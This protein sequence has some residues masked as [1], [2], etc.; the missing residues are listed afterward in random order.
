[1]STP[2]LNDV[3]A[4]VTERIGG[5]SAAARGEY[6]ERTRKRK[7]VEPARGKLACANLA[8][9]LAASGE[10]KA[11]L[12]QAIPNIGVVTSYN[13]MLS[14]HQPFE[15]Y[16]EVIRAAARL[17]GATAQVA[18]GVPAMCDGVTQGRAGM[19]LS[20]FSRD[21]IALATAVA[22]SHE[23]FDSALLLGICDKIVP[24]LFIGAASFGQLPIL[25]VPG[26]PM[27]TGNI[28]NKQKA[29][30]RQRYAEGLATRDEL[31]SA[32]MNSYHNAGTC[33]FYGTANSNQLLMEMMGLHVPGAAFVNPNTP[34]R[35]ALTVA[36]TQRAAATTALGPDYLP[37]VEVIDE[38]SFVNAIV[39]LMATGGSTNHVIHLVAMA[40]ACGLTITW[41][42]MADISRVTPLLARVYP[43]GEAD[44]NQ[45][46]AAGGMAFVVREL[47]EAGL[48]HEDVNTVWGPGLRA[49]AK[50]PF[51]D[52]GKLVWRDG[53]ARSAEEK[54]LRPASNPFSADGG[55]KLL[56]GNL[57]KSVIKTSAVDPKYW[58][59]TAPARVFE[60]QESLAA[61]LKAGI[62]GDFIA[63]VRGQ[64]P[65]ANGMPELHKLIPALSGL[66]AKGRRVAIVTDGRMSGASGKVPSAIHLT[67]EAAADGPI[68]RLR[69]GDIIR[70]DAAA[71]VLEAQVDAAVF[72]ARTPIKP[73]V[74]DITFGVGRELFTRLREGA[75][76]AD[77]GASIL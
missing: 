66:M 48:A 17:A 52:G 64:G 39:G 31:L 77:E 53:A 24:G 33:T 35:H 63:V 5:R 14:A 34:L 25:F 74:M 56:R 4:E 11:R 65:R 21:V 8:H 37:F 13:D 58:D 40:R 73:E 6:L 41:E 3:V 61:A 15:S 43:N 68:S 70:L 54:I 38:R 47:I 20:L 16:P 28:A 62:E 32:E 51:L 9:V 42:D 50:E 76:P 29:E 45:F 1:M 46:H 57:G 69:D 49:F 23:A 12:Q 22:L 27:P 10:D 18:G 7:L 2:K 72:A 75:T 44:V 19:E 59:I 36:A 55:L 30:V 60:S 67:P 71:G 26:G